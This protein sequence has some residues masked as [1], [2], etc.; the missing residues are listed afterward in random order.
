MPLYLILS[1]TVFIILI[2][3]RHFL[4]KYLIIILMSLELILLELI[5]ANN[6][7]FIIFAVYLDDILSQVYGLLIF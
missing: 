3:G 4:S 6:I 1:S 7:N 2:F 5:L